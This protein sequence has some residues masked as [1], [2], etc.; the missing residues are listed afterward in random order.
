MFTLDLHGHLDRPTQQRHHPVQ[1]LDIFPQLNFSP[2]R[3]RME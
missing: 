1:F 2:F 3:F